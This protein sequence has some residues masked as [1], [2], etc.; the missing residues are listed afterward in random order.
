MITQNM[1]KKNKLI[2]IDW[3]CMKHIP[4]CGVYSKIHVYTIDVTDNH[5]MKLNQDDYNEW[6]IYI[7]TFK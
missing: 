5:N 6:K 3:L 2:I 4:D 7:Y 1:V